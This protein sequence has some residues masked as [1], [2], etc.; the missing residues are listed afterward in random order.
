[1]GHEKHEPIE[2]IEDR[3]AKFREG[4][5]YAGSLSFRGQVV[6]FRVLS[7]SEEMEIRRK[8]ITASM[9]YGG[10]ETEKNNFI[11]MSTL[12]LA[13]TPVG[14]SKVPSLPIALLDKM[15]SDEL[16]FLY[17]EYIKIMDDANPSIERIGTEEFRSL[18]DLVKKNGVGSRDLSLKQLRAIFIAFQDLIQ[19]VDFQ[20]SPMDSSSGGQ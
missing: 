16:K 7:R 14:P 8:A 17:D 15:T 5:R 11:Q 9:H 18:V 1:M 4:A 6:H 20:T 10:D 12:Q 19:R 3:L 2:T 13:S